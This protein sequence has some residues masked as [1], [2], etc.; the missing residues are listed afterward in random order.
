VATASGTSFAELSLRGS[1][2]PYHSIE[3]GVSHV[4]PLLSPYQPPAEAELEPLNR[5]GVARAVDR[6]GARERWRIGEPYVGEDVPV[7]LV[8]RARSA[9]SSGRERRRCSPD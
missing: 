7:L 4:H 6:V 8:R 2:R 3:T 1:L 9:P 5:D